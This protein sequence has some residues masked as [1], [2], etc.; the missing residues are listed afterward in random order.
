MKIMLVTDAAAPQ[1]NGVVIT[2]ATLTQELVHLGHDVRTISPAS[3]A[4]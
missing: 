2:L 4:T 1:I 3:C